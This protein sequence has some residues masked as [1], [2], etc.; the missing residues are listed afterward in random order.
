MFKYKHCHCHRLTLV[1]LAA[2]AG[3]WSNVRSW[4]RC[5]R[6]CVSLWSDNHIMPWKWRRAPTKI[7]SIVFWHRF[8]AGKANFWFL[9]WGFLGKAPKEKKKIKKKHRAIASKMF[10]LSTMMIMMMSNLTRDRLSP[11]HLAKGVILKASQCPK[12][13]IALLGQH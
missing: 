10:Q 3:S 7:P 8:Q 6:P 4:R 9:L 13:S 12:R 2:I 11:T 1:L 5:Q